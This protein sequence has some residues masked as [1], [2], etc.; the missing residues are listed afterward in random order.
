M[1][2]LPAKE[3]IS[4]VVPVY[5]EEKNIRVLYDRLV[6]VLD[7][8]G[9]LF[10]LLFVNDGSSDA[11]S[12]ILKHL[13]NKDPRVKVINL[14]RNFG[15]QA[16]LTAGMDHSRGKAV[17]CL[18]ADLQHPPEVILSMIAKWKEGHDIVFGVRRETEGIGIL[19][20]ITSKIFYLAFNGLSQRKI[21]MAAADYRLISEK[22]VSVFREDIRERNR[23]LRGLMDWVGFRQVTVE[24]IAERRFAGKSK[25]SW[26]KM[27]TFAATGFTSFS[28]IPLRLSLLAGIVV[29]FLA[30]CYGM[31]AIGMKVFT[32]AT[33]P[34]WTSLAVV[35]TFI[36]AVQLIFIGVLGEYI[37]NIFEEVKNRPIYIVADT[38]S[39]KEEGG[40]KIQSAVADR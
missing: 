13:V 36:N 33:I 6:G 27:F 26:A 1:A 32:N 19:K 35:I 2:N 25:Y 34:G 30:L 3:L 39:Q 31:Y 5:N 20:R 4:V 28:V 11:S 15:H 9:H 37:G 10:E 14:S 18:D 17:V 7:G 40:S 22:V 16:A 29:A 38:L 12:V 23:F 21:N 24:Y 8:A